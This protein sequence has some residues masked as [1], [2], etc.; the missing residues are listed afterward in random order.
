MYIFF[1]R[2]TGNYVKILSK[3]ILKMKKGGYAIYFWDRNYTWKNVFAAENTKVP[4]LLCVSAYMVLFLLLV[5][6]FER[7]I[8]QV[9]K[10]EILCL[11]ESI[12]NKGRLQAYA[13]EWWS[14]TNHWGGRG[15]G[16]TVCKWVQTTNQTSL[17]SICFISNGLEI[18]QVSCWFEG[19]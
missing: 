18:K 11:Y 1:R 9:H 14:C 17:N 13:W 10:Y 2:T 6:Q 5:D 19:N 4:K 16:P 12:T 3:F 8:K 15:G 7:L